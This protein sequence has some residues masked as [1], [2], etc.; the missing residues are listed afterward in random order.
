MRF[1]LDRFPVAAPFQAEIPSEHSDGF[2]LRRF[3]EILRSFEYADIERD[4]EVVIRISA[5]CVGDD[6]PRFGDT[7]LEGRYGVENCPSVLA[8]KSREPEGFTV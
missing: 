4:P 6:R 5:A 3:V 2:I 7:D 1:V 8:S